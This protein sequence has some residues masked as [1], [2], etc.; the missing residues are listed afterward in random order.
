MS[1][2]LLLEQVIEI[3]CT[4]AKSTDYGLTLSDKS[5]LRVA[6]DSC[7]EFLVQAELKAIQ[8]GL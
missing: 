1:A 3:Q 8:K 4:L 6:T 2:H 7:T 5:A